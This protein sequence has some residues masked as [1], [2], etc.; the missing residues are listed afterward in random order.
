MV[1]RLTTAS[2]RLLAVATI[3]LWAA[4][5]SASADPRPQLW[6]HNL[7]FDLATGSPAPLCIAA[8]ESEPDPL[9][10]ELDDEFASIVTGFPDPHESFN[11]RILGFNRFIG[12]YL[13][14]PITDMYGLVVPRPVKRAIIR[15]RANIDS[16]PIFVNDLLQLR[17]KRAGTTLLRFG[18]NSTAGLA[19]I[20]DPARRLGL[21]SHRSDF[22]QTLAYAGVRSGP[23]LI[24]PVIGPSTARDAIGTITDSIMNPITFWLGFG[25][26]QTL[27]YGT[28]TGVS[29][30]DL[31][32][33]AL[34]ALESSLDYYAALRNGYYQTRQAQLWSEEPEPEWRQRVCQSM[35]A[36]LGRQRWRMPPSCQRANY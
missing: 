16:V 12:R 24:I 28:T 26:L 4:A 19:G 27:T 9:F 23:Y 11:R 15:I 36:R 14:D 5:T 34:H 22:G 33:E 3:V 18:I 31:H 35:L 32:S 17:P 1:G 13:L 20:F 10:D 7:L 2:G 30:R 25:S 8:A 21:V 6:S 29:I